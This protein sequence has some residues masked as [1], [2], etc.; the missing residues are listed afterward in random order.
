MALTGAQKAA[1]EKKALAAGTK[2]EGMRMLLQ[3]DYS[4]RETADVFGAPYGF[5]YGVAQRLAGGDKPAGATRRVAKAKAT[6][7]PARPVAKAKAAAPARAAKKTVAKPKA[8]KA[9]SKA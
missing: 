5:A 7:A 6:K 4:V 1:L 8:A 3:A 2:S 9:K